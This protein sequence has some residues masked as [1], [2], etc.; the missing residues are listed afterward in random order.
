VGPDE[1]NATTARRLPLLTAARGGTLGSRLAF[2]A[3]RRFGW[4]VVLATP[5]PRRAVVV[6]YPHTSNW[7]FV[8]GVLAR[9]AISID[10]HW[11]GKHT[12]FATPLRGWFERRGGIA[13]DRGDPAGIVDALVARFASRDEFVLAIT[14]EGTRRRTAHWKRGFHRIAVAARVPI[15]LAFVDRPTRTIGIGAWIEPT[16]DADADLATMRAFYR[17]KR[18]WIAGNAGEIAFRPPYRDPDER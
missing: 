9:S 2:A 13:V 5:V 11:L 17:D 3:L 4:R 8:V 18:G 1:A 14:P 7:D 16:G 15:G 10:V 6:F 12:L